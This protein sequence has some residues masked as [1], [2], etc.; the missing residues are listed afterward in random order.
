M[1][2]DRLATLRAFI[3]RSPRDPFPRYGVAMELRQQGDLEGSVGA[4][5]ELIRDFPDYLPTYL[6]A[7]GVLAE[8]GRRGDSARTYRRGIEVATAQGNQH[9]RSEL[10]A[11]LAELPADAAEP[12]DAGEDR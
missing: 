4:F 11:A 8:V 3:A 6:M 5:E 12:G 10:E 1:P 7:G 9:A 2:I